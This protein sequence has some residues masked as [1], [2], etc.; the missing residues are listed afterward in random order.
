MFLLQVIIS[1]SVCS[2]QRKS[3]RKSKSL[4]RV[5][6]CKS[7]CFCVFVYILPGVSPQVYEG[8]AADCFTRLLS[9]FQAKRGKET[10]EKTA[11]GR[12]AAHKG[13]EAARMEM[14]TYLAMRDEDE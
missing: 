12:T 10:R 9:H 2:A 14:E 1:K 5:C 13:K 7:V 3:K 6:N 11:R 4:E 8:I